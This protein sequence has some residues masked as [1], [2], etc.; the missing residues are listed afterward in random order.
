MDDFCFWTTAFHLFN[1]CGNQFVESVFFFNFFNVFWSTVFMRCTHWS[2]LGFI[3]SN[4][5]FIFIYIYILH[6][7]YVPDSW[8]KKNLI[9]KSLDCFSRPIYSVCVYFQ[10]FHSFFE[11]NERTRKINIV[12]WMD[13]KL[14]SVFIKLK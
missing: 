11:K 5:I 8:S 2:I 4:R 9:G 6:L 7:Y 3:S 1:Y 14:V 10:W 12:I 13:C